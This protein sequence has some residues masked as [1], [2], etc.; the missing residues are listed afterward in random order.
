[1]TDQ[2]PDTPKRNWAL[3]WTL[4]AVATLAAATAIG[5]IAMYIANFNLLEWM[6]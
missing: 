5:A 1:M 4:V 3:I 2:S 6:E